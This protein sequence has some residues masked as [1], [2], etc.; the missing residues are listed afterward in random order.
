MSLAQILPVLLRPMWCRE[1]E[2][3][4][5][6]AKLH[7]ISSPAKTL[8]TR[9]HRYAQIVQ[10]LNQI[11]TCHERG[12]LAYLHDGREGPGRVDDSRHDVASVSAKTSSTPRTRSKSGRSLRL[13]SGSKSSRRRLAVT[14][15]G[16]GFT[17]KLNLH[18]RL[19]AWTL[20][21]K[22]RRSPS[23]WQR[24]CSTTTQSPQPTS[25]WRLKRVRCVPLT[26][27]ALSFDKLVGCHPLRS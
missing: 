27:E 14:L 19:R 20:T 15:T 3:N 18:P 7:R 21:R 25:G 5:H 10:S 12:D 8:V 22:R 9:G 16:F 24:C 1:R 6:G 17:R 13:V 26:G 2:S 23:A 11:G 4:P